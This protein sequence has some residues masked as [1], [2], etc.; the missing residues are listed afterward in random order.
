[1]ENNTQLKLKALGIYQ[2]I[3]GGIG[4]GLTFWSVS[5]LT[6]IVAPPLFLV[7][8]AIGLYAYSIYC[9]VLL[10]KKNRSELRH[11]LINQFFQLVNFSIL[12]FTFQ[13][14]SGLFLS[15]GL[16]LS[17]SFSLTFGLDLSSWQ[18][19]VHD[20]TKPL[21]VNFNLIAFLL[22]VFIDRTKREM[23]REQTKKQ[24]ASIGQ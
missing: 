21:I 20:D 9:G 7:L 23:Q 2:I 13:Y 15:I 17:N 4:L 12:G 24:I 22:I 14:V 16:D 5:K 3:G 6:I 18:I 19:A 10:L 1:M 8:I 11:S